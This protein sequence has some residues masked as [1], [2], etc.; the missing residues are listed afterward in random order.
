MANSLPKHKPDYRLWV[1]TVEDIKLLVDEA[2]NYADPR[3]TIGTIIYAA[4]EDQYYSIKGNNH[5]VNGYELLRP[6]SGAIF[7]GNTEPDIDKNSKLD[8]LWVVDSDDVS[9]EEYI[10]GYFPEE[11]IITSLKNRVGKLEEQVKSLM[12]II[13]YGAIAG[14]S[15][16]GGRTSIMG[17]SPVCTNPTTD[18]DEPT[19]DGSVKPSELLATVPNFSIKHDTIENFKKNYQ[20]L[21]NGELIWIRNGENINVGDPGLYMYAANKLYVGFISLASGSGNAG[22]SGGSGGSGSLVTIEVKDNGI[23]D[24]LSNRTSVNSDGILTIDD[25]ENFN[26]DENGILNIKGIEPDEDI[27][28]PDTPEVEDGIISKVED[29]ILNISSTAKLFIEDGVLIINDSNAIEDGL[30]KL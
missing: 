10:H 8:A 3:V 21:I 19:D 14:D 7:F 23:L 16:I 26:V 20:N 18:E 30:I 15:T 9:T 4:E 27:I 25:T 17:M 29:N 6:N 24:I 1:D 5:K 22:G 13:E 2:N 11:N 12:S 28:T